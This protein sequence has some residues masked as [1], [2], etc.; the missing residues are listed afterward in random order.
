LEARVDTYCLAQ[1]NIARAC[2]SLQDPRMRDFIARLEAIN[3]LAERSPGFIWRLKAEDGRASSYVRVFDDDRILINMST[4]QSLEAL[5]AY[6]YRSEHADLLRQRARW[7]APMPGP[8]LALWWV[9][10]GS[11][12]TVEQGRERLALLASHGP[13]PAAFTFKNSFGVTL[14]EH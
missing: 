12:V 2:A 3:E 7:F 11:V 10:T 8:A 9:R 6:V 5:R 4:W 1:I 14:A 13:T